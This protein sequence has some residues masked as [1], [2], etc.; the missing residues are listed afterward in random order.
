M[1]I[2]VVCG[3]GCRRKN[4]GNHICPGI[5][6]YLAP[7]GRP[8]FFPH[9]LSFPSNLQILPFGYGGAPGPAGVGNVAGAGNLFMESCIWSFPF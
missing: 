2:V 7:P 1:L 3:P 4:N 5:T 8:L 9:L 6:S